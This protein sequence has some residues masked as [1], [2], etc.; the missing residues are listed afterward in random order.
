MEHLL[1][2]NI[3]LVY[4]FRVIRSFLLIAPILVPFLKSYG[5]SQTEIYILESVWAVTIFLLEVPSGYFADYLGR[6]FSISMGAFLS[7][8]GFIIYC[9]YP[10]FYWMILAHI[11]FGTGYSFISGADSALAFDSLALLSKHEEYKKFEGNSIAVMGVS[12]AVASVIGGV[13]AVTSLDAPVILQTIVYSLMLVCC[14]FLTEPER[15]KLKGESPVK[16]LLKITYFSLHGENRIKWLILYG[17]VAGTLTHTMVWLT[18]PYYELVGI[19]LGWFGVL[20]AIQMLALGI[21]AR[22]AGYYERVVGERYALPSLLL[23]GIVTYVLIGMSPSIWCLPALLGF[24]FVRGV[25]MPILMHRLNELVESDIRAT[26][27]SVRN[28]VQK[29]LY[30]LLGP[31]VGVAADLWSLQTALIASAI[32]YSFL[33]GLVVVGLLRSRNT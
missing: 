25:H 29:L 28:L 14:L 9:L 5:L 7:T 15:V 4:L 21:F 30:A 20:W 19:P 6:K 22:S 1:R 2:R 31:F 26:V 8:M 33:S 11:L 13:V 12:E 10:E 3:R 32:L 24:Y 17:A 18:Q 23:I 27:L 16:D